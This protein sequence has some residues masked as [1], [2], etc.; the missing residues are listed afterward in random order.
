M[1]TTMQMK[2]EDTYAIGADSDD[3][4]YD[5]EGDNDED[6][7]DVDEGGH[8]RNDR[9]HRRAYHYQ[10]QHQHHRHHNHR[11]NHHQHAR[12]LYFSTVLRASRRGVEFATHGRMRRQPSGT[13]S[14]SQLQRQRA[15]S[16]MPCAVNMIQVARDFAAWR[17]YAALVHERTHWNHDCVVVGSSTNRICF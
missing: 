6:N 4:V 9:D 2:D 7:D 13:P 17:V 5:D 8:N 11:H 12:Q 15:R 14:N 1:T 3:D 16:C 10:H